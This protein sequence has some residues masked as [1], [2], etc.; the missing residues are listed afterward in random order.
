MTILTEYRWKCNYCGNVS[1]ALKYDEDKPRGWKAFRKVMNTPHF[2]TDAHRAAW[3][4]E[5]GAKHE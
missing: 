3:L 1:P 5:T 2:C 4:A